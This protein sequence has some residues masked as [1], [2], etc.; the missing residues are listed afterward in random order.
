MD[1]KLQL[2]LIQIDPFLPEFYKCLL[3]GDNFLLNLAVMDMGFR[4]MTSDRV[5]QSGYCVSGQTIAEATRNIEGMPCNQIIILNIGS[6]DIAHGKELID[7]MYE[8]VALFKTCMDNEITP[9]VTTLAPLANYRTGNRG[10]VTNGFN[11]F[12]RYNPC[13]FPVI[14]IHDAFIDR[15]GLV[16]Q[17]FYQST[18]RHVS[19]IRK[20][21]VFWNRFG[22]RTV[23][24]I[25]KQELGTAFLQILMK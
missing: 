19:G 20:P 11:E 6:V 16:D 3:V 1:L 17:R 22:H 9:I 24:R 7:L 13:N 14:D 15:K 12:L 10:D 4:M 21:L 18:P 23:M 2:P 25:L 8:M 5:L